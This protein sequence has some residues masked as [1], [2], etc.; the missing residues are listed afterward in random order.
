LI[1][2]NYDRKITISTAGSRKATRWPPQNIFIS[3]FW[4]RFETPVR[5][6]ETLRD[7]LS[8]PKSKQDDLKDVGGYVAGMLVANRRKG[9]NVIGRDVVTLDLDNIQPGGTQDVLRRIDALGCGYA[10]YSTRKHET[11]KPRLRALFPLN[12]TASPDECEAVS[13]KLASII[14]IDLCDPTTFETSRLMYWPSCCADSQYIFQ[15]GDK[16]FLDVDGLLGMYAN[17]RNVAEWPE[18]PGAQQTHV[19]LAAKQGDPIA[20]TGIVGAFCKTYDIYRAMDAFLLGVYIPCD[21][22]ENRFTFTGG[23]TVGGAVIYDNGNF[24]FS[25]HATDPAGGKLCN[26]FDLVRLHRF[27]NLD[28]DAKPETPTNKLPSYTAMCELA[29]SDSYVAALLNQERYEK[30]TQEFA[31]PPDDNANWISKLAVSA[32]T[33][34]PAKTT[35][36]IL[37][38]LENDPLIKGK[39]AFDEFA[40]RG[41]V[42]GALPWDQRNIRR[43]WGDVDDAGLRHYMEHT[44]GISG[45]DRIFDAVALCGRKHAFNEVKEYLMSLEWDELPRLDT[46]F[47]DYLGAADTPY[48]RSVTR[49]IFTAAVAR[50][51]TPGCKFDNMPILTGPQGLGKSTLLNKM[52]RAWFSDSLKTFEGKEA[53]EQVQGVW[54][55]EVGELEAF[56]RSEIGRIKQFLSQLDDIF[57]AA[58]G[59]R[60]ERHPR[61]CIFFGTSNNGEYLRDK[62][63]NRRFWPVDLAVQQPIKNV[64]RDLNDEVGQLWAE[65]YARWQ[66]GEPLYLSGDIEAAAQAEQETHRERSAREGFIREFIEKPVP[67]DWAKWP[68]DRR[69]MYWSGGMVEGTAR[70]VERDRVCALEVWCECF[71]G[72]PKFMKYSDAAEINGIISMIPGWKR[73]RNGARF[74]YCGYQRGFER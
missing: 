8:F 28:D 34:T 46:L 64:F 52:G 58:Y 49:K 70:L 25:H 62:T 51:M 71:N 26:A 44:Y 45:K 22:G 15:Y 69:R 12:K 36:N 17:W 1:F 13:R 39:I 67:E 16:P 40:N 19:K 7:Y 61:R 42:L 23:S 9:N 37:I 20:K 10:V 29:V 24:L 66:L 27:S 53:S 30:A 38:V 41:L 18:V 32:T 48:I 68:M 33:G 21:D 35:D 5:S 6:T 11:G 2:L 56:N 55:I 54:I 72:D 50:A 63:G 57:R 74:G 65:A 3:E 14:G 47:I 43:D 60:T 73:Q 31:T 59:R 4:G